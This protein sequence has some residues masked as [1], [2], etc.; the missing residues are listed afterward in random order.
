MVL[1]QGAACVMHLEINWVLLID[2]FF[3]VQE[4]IEGKSLAQ[5]VEAGWQPA[6]KEV[7]RIADE[8]LTTFSYLQKEQVTYSNAEIC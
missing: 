3:G 1:T 5:M 8:L 6:Q 7:E 4:L 2:V